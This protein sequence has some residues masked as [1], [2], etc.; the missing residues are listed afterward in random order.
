MQ[1]EK[2]RNVP[3][4]EKAQ[5]HGVAYGLTQQEQRAPRGPEARDGASGEE[6]TGAEGAARNRPR[7]CTISRSLWAQ[8]W[9]WKRERHEQSCILEGTLPVPPAP[10]PETRT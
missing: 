1:W 4:C 2:V 8:G 9:S 10:E 3:V 7:S 5:E 6:V